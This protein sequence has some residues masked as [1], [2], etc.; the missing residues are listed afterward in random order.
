MPGGG[1]GVKTE[2]YY[3]LPSVI[4]D[5]WGKGERDEAGANH[6]QGVMER[7]REAED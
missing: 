1:E 4:Y 3:E 6:Q 7:D 5:V 2:D